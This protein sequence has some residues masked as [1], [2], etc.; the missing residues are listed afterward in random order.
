MS[1]VQWVRLD[2]VTKGMSYLTET[3][4]V[5]HDGELKQLC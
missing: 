3:G 2:L 5:A 4:H 1:G